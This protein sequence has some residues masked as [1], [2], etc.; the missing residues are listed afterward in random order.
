MSRGIETP[1]AAQAAW[2]SPEQSKLPGP[3]SE[4]VDDYIDR[5][6]E[7]IDLK[8]QLLQQTRGLEALGLEVQQLVDD[9]DAEQSQASVAELVPQWTMPDDPPSL[10]ARPMRIYFD[11]IWTRNHHGEEIRDDGGAARVE[12]DFHL[13]VV[14]G[15]LRP[16][17]EVLGGESLQAHV[18]VVRRRFEHVHQHPLAVREVRRILLEH[19]AASGLPGPR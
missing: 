8:I 7:A 1:A 2:A 18:A 4:F 12:G 10:G 13:G 5:G 6:L 15:G 11:D 16:D 9:F 17:H 14:L 19:A 3:V